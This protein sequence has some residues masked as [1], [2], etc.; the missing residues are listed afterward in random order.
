ME[1]IY[2]TR[3]SEETKL[4]E[5]KIGLL[6]DSHCFGRISGPPSFGVEHI[7]GVVTIMPTDPQTCVYI[8]HFYENIDIDFDIDHVELLKE[9]NVVDFRIDNTNYKYVSKLGR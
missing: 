1:W 8:E 7:E 4:L 3:S 5:E 2:K 9:E 6:E